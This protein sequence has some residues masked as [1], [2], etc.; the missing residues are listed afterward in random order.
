MKKE[1][2]FKLGIC[3]SGGGARGFGH[4]GILQALKEQD[5]KPSIICG[6]SAGS[7]VG[8]FYADGKS[9][10]D[11]LT[12][13]KDQ[14]GID[15]VGFS[16]FKKGLLST[17]KLLK[18]L[19][20]HLETQSFESLKIPLIA[21]VVNINNGKLEFF[22][23]GNLPVALQASSAF[24]GVFEAVRI[25]GHW[26]CDGGLIN[27]MPASYLR[28]KC[29]MVIGVNVNPPL[30]YKPETEGFTE[31]MWR[32]LRIFIIT[33]TEP[34]IP[35]CDIYICPPALGEFEIIDMRKSTEIYQAAYDYMCGWLNDPYNLETVNKLKQ[36]E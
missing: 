2:K 25:G 16:L 27:N 14:K 9:P 15:V 30:T 29:E 35:N 3:L 18:L 33:N 8:A 10:E 26:Y 6:A 5:I 23:S 36:L 34:E 22:K 17:E 31:L 21:A 19:E 24:P 12:I 28:D 13:F 32:M 1:K 7:I 4:L 11:I 20:D